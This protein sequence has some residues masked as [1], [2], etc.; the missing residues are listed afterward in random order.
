[1]IWILFRA[2]R[3]RCRFTLWHHMGFD[4]YIEKAA[5][6]RAKCRENA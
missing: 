1:L 5:A 2:G 3:G 6:A 4:E